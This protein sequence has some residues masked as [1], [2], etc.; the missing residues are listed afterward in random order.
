[1]YGDEL[2]GTTPTAICGM[3]VSRYHSRSMLQQPSPTQ[4]NPH[5]YVLL[6]TLRARKHP[7]LTKYDQDVTIRA[8]KV[9]EG[10]SPRS[11]I[12]RRVCAHPVQIMWPWWRMKRPAVGWQRRIGANPRVMVA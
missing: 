11:T 5:C 9:L 2:V 10:C 3:I 12:P 6:E 7:S 8:C 4:T 1:M